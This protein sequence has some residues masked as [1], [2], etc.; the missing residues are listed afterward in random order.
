MRRTWSVSVGANSSA[1]AKEQ[2]TAQEM[3]AMGMRKRVAS[4]NGDRRARHGTTA[5]FL[6]DRSVRG[7]C[8]LLLLCGTAVVVVVDVRRRFPYISLVRRRGPLSTL[9]IDVVLQVVSTRSG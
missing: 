2:W 8:L 5:G 4:V 6:I 9:P 1:A 3:D 7:A